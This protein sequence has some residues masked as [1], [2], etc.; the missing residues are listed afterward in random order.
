LIYRINKGKHRATIPA[1]GLWYGAPTLVR[2]VT[3]D[4]SCIYDLNPDRAVLTGDDPQFDWN[5]LFGF[6]FIS[7]GHIQD[8][9]R[10]GWRSDLKSGRIILAAFCHVDGKIESKEL[11]GVYPFKTYRLKI[12]IPHHGF[13][14]FT[15]S[16]PKTGAIFDMEVIEF[17]HDKKW[18]Y[19]LGFYFGG[20]LPAPHKMSVRIQKP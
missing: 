13:Y 8:S 7:G 4:D 19:R 20:D 2:D 6:G 15:V 11:F 16:D 18:A 10:F 1:I 9:A 14:R 5:K 3:F 17:N 12:D